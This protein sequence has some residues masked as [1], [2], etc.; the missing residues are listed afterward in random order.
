[1]LPIGGSYE[2][3]HRISSQSSQGHC[4]DELI[5]ASEGQILPDELDLLIH[6]K[7][8]VQH[9]ADACRHAPGTHCC[10]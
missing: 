8:H 5:D 1:M 10:V 6:W 2:E 7:I 4:L 3:A 9:D